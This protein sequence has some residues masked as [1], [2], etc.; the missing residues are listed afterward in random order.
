MKIPNK[1]K[2]AQIQGA[3]FGYW[4]ERSEV[5]QC[6]ADHPVRRN[7]GG[8]ASGRVVDHIGGHFALPQ[9]SAGYKL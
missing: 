2:P 9:I 8:Q 3:Q 5:G 6:H 4:C 7:A 1:A